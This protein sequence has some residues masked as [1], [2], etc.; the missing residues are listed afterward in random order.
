MLSILRHFE[1]AA[2]M[3]LELTELLHWLGSTDSD[4]DRHKLRL[5][6]LDR[7]NWR[8]VAI[9]EKF[10]SICEFEREKT[11]GERRWFVYNHK[12]LQRD[13]R[14]YTNQPLLGLHNVV[15]GRRK[16][17]VS[18]REIKSDEN[19]KMNNCSALSMCRSLLQRISEKQIVLT[20]WGHFKSKNIWLRTYFSFIVLLISHDFALISVTTLQIDKTT[21]SFTSARGMGNKKFT[22]LFLFLIFTI[23]LL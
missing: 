19:R 15:E 1:L 14:M 12:Y 23:H 17:H 22:I 20:F 4:D 7:I 13:V 5:S 18:E 11:T 21:R 16:F 8:R 6:Q 3:F 2:D 9:C 10:D